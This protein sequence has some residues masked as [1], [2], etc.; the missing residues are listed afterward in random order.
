MA[1]SD[2]E[3][4]ELEHLVHLEEID[5]ARDNLLD[6][7]KKTMPEFEA[8]EFHK[9][10]YKILDHFA[11]GLIRRLMVTIAPQH[12]KSLGSTIKLPSYLLG[13]NPDTKIAIGSYSATFARK[14]NRHVQR[15]IDT[16]VYNEIFPNT[17]LNTSNIVTIAGQYLRNSEEFEIVGK[18]GGLKAVGRGGPLT[19]NPVD[20]MIMDDLYKDAAEGNSPVIRNSVWDWY[21][22]VVTKRLHNDSQQLIVF[23]R[24]HKDDL[25]GMIEEKREVITITD[26]EQLYEL[27]DDFDGWIK[28]NFEAIK[29]GNPT[30]IDQREEG[31]ALYPSK[32]SLKKLL[33][34]RDMDPETFECMNQGNPISQSGLLYRPFATYH[35]ND[36]PQMKIVKSYVDTADKG[37]DYLCAIHY[38]VPL[39]YND[40]RRFVLDVVYTDEPMEITE[41]LLAKSLDNNKV[42]EAT[43]ESNNGGRGF[44]RAVEKMVSANVTINWF[45]QSD[46]KESRIVSNAAAVNKRMVFPIGW[47]NMWPK[48]HDHLKFYKKLFNANTQ[49]GAP[50]VLTGIVEADTAKSQSKIQW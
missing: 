43:V 49:D 24:W 25:I 13:K 46:N 21:S 29:T 28:I 39:D 34:E 18:K 4:S 26:I 33:E 12:G 15:E 47:D 35:P 7:T 45:H 6:F 32:H 5:D 16:E 19:G 23:T 8:T 30:P 48:F 3:L 42:N 11:D 10:Y 44:A 22:S 14:F 20:V 27:S 37:K 1:L 38:G 50:D 41:P 9:T 2:K 36:M 31:D 17:A 40:E